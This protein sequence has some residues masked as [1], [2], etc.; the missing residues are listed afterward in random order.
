[1]RWLLTVILVLSLALGVMACEEEEEGEATATVVEPTATVVEPTATVVEPTATPVE[2]G[3]VPEGWERHTTAN[4]QVDLPETWDAFDP[5][6]ETLDTVRE[7]LATFNPDFAALFEQTVSLE[8]LEFLAFDTESVE[9]VNN[10][11]LI[12][13][14]SP[15]PLTV[16]AAIAQ[17]E[18]MYSD[19]GI[20]VLATDSDL[21][22]GGLKAGSI[23]VSMS[24]GPYEVRE[25]Q[26][27]VL[28]KPDLFF[29]LTFSANADDFDALE[30]PF[31]QM[32]KSFRVLESR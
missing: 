26:Y 7:A 32:A 29:V 31:E 5:T 12:R 10:L 30:L 16:P 24:F 13:Q 25:V 27:I 11:N 3:V 1:M 28:P 21:T 18:T 8:L 17:A 15:L 2:E 19:L 22:I 14:E 9:F 23:Q 20:T 4:I 6:E